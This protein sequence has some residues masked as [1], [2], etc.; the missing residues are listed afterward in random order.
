MDFR[1][2]KWGAACAALLLTAACSTTT[3]QT[4]TP[5]TQ[6][7]ATDAVM[8]NGNTAFG[9]DP[10]MV[11]RGKSLFTSKGCNG[12]HTIGKGRSAGPD[13]KGVTQRRTTEWLHSWMMDPPAMAKTDPTAQA[14]VKEYNGMVMPKVPLT[15]D[16]INAL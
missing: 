13:L 14:M 10:K 3:N 12:C 8:A 9:S 4:D 2:I 5:S 7:A 6:P 11:S 16:D 1:N 15:H